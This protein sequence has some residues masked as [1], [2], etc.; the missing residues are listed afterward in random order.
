MI[1]ITQ[2]LIDKGNAYSADDG[3]YFSVESAQRSTVN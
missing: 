3:V 1:R 2:D